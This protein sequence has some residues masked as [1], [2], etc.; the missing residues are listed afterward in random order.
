MPTDIHKLPLAE[1]ADGLRAGERSPNDVLATACDRIDAVDGELRSFVCEPGRRERVINAAS[2]LSRDPSRPP[3][4]G[5]PVGIKDIIHVDGMETRAGSAVPPELFSGKEATCVTRL[6]QAGAIVL[7]KTATTEFAGMGPGL[8]RNPHDISHSPGGSSSGSAA[9]V[10]A[11]LCP[12]ALGSQT[13]GSVIRPA[14]F[15]G[16]VGFKPSFNRIP[17]DGVLT[18][19]HS[20]DHVGLFTQTAAGIELAASVVCSD[21][22]E[23]AKT[24]RDRPRIGIP[25]GVYLERTDEHALAAFEGQLEALQREGFDIER[26]PVPSF[27]TFDALDRRHQQMV[28]AELAAVHDRWY[29][30]YRPFYRTKLADNIDD[31]QSVSAADL[32][33]GRMSRFRFRR[34]LATRRREASIDLWAAPAAAGEA[35]ESIRTTGDPVMNRPWTH[36]GVPVVTLPAGRGKN[37]LPLGIQFAGEYGADEELLSWARLLEQSLTGA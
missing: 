4:F 5:V 12:L 8:T 27:E 30:A 6:K 21:W 17:R 15:C 13:G 35:P 10:A 14:A 3:L 36:A 32:A 7:G 24:P 29:P 20:A 1:M 18:R 16:I 25:E 9:A 19:S 34:Q 23:R 28:K 26:L 2:D 11:G 31:G 37:G 22:R 33:A